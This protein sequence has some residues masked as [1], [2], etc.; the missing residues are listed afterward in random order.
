M[1]RVLVPVDRNVERAREQVAYVTSLPGGSNEIEAKVLFV[2][3]AD[4]AGAPQRDFD[5]IESARTAVEGIKDA[6]ISCEGE[7]RK[8][9]IARKILDAAEEYDADQVVMAGRDRS[10]VMKVILGSVTQDVAMSTER[11]VVVLG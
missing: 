11:P 1:Y 10:G 2:E 5:D 9:M 4:Y 3:E 7:M 8:G 6:G